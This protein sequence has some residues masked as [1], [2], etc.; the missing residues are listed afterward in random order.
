MIIDSRGWLW[1]CQ[2]DG[3]VIVY[4]PGNDLD[5]TMQ[6]TNGERLGA[7]TGNGGLPNNSVWCIVEDKENDIWV[8]TDEGI[9]TFFCAGSVFSNNGCD[10]DRV[11]VERD[12]FIGYLFS[13]EIVKSI[14]VDGA[15]RKWVGTSERGVFSL[16]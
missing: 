1:M 16:C 15:N 10:A 11:K 9:G 12:G 6:M 7:G 4:N 14:A 8:G 3:D 13:T 5:N 2:R